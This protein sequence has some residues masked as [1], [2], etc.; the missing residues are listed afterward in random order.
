[1]SNAGSSFV[2]TVGAVLI[3]AWAVGSGFKYLSQA[4]YASNPHSKP[5]TT[6][7]IS[8]LGSFSLMACC[9]LLCV[10]LLFNESQAGHFPFANFFFG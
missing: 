7:S 6:S 5:K 8:V 2:S 3:F 1:M 9:V 4:P 10:V